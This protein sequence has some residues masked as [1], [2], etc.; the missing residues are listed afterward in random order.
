MAK[1][2]VTEAIAVRKKLES[3][4]ADLQRVNALP[5]TVNLAPNMMQKAAALMT[6]LDGSI[7]KCQIIEMSGG[8]CEEA[9]PMT[10]KDASP[11]GQEAR[12]LAGLMK[13]M[14]QKLDRSAAL[15]A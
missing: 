13:D 8:K 10:S 15:G 9:V 11:K 1:K 14:L 5:Q 2:K 6:E 4:L 7:K 12:K 3:P